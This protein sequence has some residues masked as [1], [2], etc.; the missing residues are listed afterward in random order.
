MAL[1]ALIPLLFV[2]SVGVG[3]GADQTWRL[4]VRPRT[5]ELLSNTG[6]L[7]VACVLASAALGTAAA[8][9]V[10]R[11]NLPGRRGWNAVLVAPIF[12]AN[13]MLTYF[14]GSQVELRDDDLGPNSNRHYLAVERVKTLTT[15]QREIL[16][17]IAAGHRT[18]Q[19]AH[20]L[21]LSEKTVK[22]H[23]SLLL[24]NLHTS[25]IADAIRLAVEAGL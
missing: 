1:L 24:A 8:W 6:R 15:R 13:G 7:L 22:M 16:Q 3:L 18:K 11:T 10:E 4:V 25:N 19:I 9:L 21:G 17:L 23:R 12:D 14:L 20:V 2:I 5:G